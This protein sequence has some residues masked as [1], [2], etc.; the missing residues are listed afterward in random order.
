MKRASPL[1]ACLLVP[2]GAFG[3]DR[4]S[5]WACSPPGDWPISSLHLVMVPELA[6]RGFVEGRNLTVVPV[7]NLIRLAGDGQMGDASVACGT[8]VD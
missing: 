6:Q 2:D 5:R 4:V 1:L 3:E 8:C 7:G